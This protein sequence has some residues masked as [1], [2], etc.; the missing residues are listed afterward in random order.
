MIPEAVCMVRSHWRRSAAEKGLR[1][2]PMGTPKITDWGEAGEREGKVEKCN[3]MKQK[4]REEGVRKEGLV[5]W[6]SVLGMLRKRKTGSSN[7]E[8]VGP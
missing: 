1:T 5:N 7:M 2:R 4:P 8:G 6:A 3:E